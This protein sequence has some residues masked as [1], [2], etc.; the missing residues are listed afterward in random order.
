MNHQD[1]ICVSYGVILLLTK[2]KY[3]LTAVTKMLLVV[4]LRSQ[5]V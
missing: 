1:S 4:Q 2:L 3:G 5:K